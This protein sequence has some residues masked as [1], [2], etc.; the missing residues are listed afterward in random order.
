MATT[1]LALAVNLAQ[2]GMKVLLIDA[3]LRNPSQHRNLKRSNDIGL[4]NFLAGAEL[5][6]SIFQ[7]T[8]IDGLYF[9][10]TGPLP[11]NPAELLAGAR[12]MSLLSTASEKVNTV[13]VMGLTMP[14]WNITATGRK[15]SP[16]KW[17]IRPGARRWRSSMSLSWLLI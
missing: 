3:D 1:A 16:L 11:P 6:G 4:A 10:G 8:D 12:M 2:L 9:M 17:N 14:R 13:T 5:S 15:I 7:E